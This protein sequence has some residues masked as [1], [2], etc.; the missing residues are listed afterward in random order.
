L[1]FK[2][3]DTITQLFDLTDYTTLFMQVVLGM[4][5]IFLFPVLV[6]FTTLIGILT[7]KFMR[8]YRRHAIV[9][10]MVVAAI[11]TPADVL[12]MLMAAFPLVLL[13]E[14]SIMMCAYTYKRV[15]KKQTL[16][17]RE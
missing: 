14:F 6:Y 16:A 7:P 8:M 10:I 15:Q 4:G 1:L 2:V 3:S 17:V 12:S 9:L 11:I 5:L 13:Y